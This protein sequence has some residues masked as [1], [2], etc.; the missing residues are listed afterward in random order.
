MR[1]HATLLV[2]LIKLLDWSLILSGGALSFY[3]LEASKNFPAYQG[4]MPTSYL[5]A[6]G[7]AFLFSAWWF[8]AFNVYKSWRGESLF[9]E[10]RT[11]LLSWGVSMMALLVFMVFT[12]TTTEFSRHWLGLWF[13]LVFVGLVLSRICLRLVLR[14]LRKKGLNQRHI[15]LVGSSVLTAQVAARVQ[16]S[17]WMGLEISGFFSDEKSAIDGLNKLG[18]LSKVVDYVEQHKVDQVWLTLS[19]KDMDKIETICRQLHS[20]SVEVLLIPDISSLRLLNHSISQIDG[21]PVINMSVSPMKG[22]N[23]IVKWLEDKLLSIFILL[24]ISPLMLII[25]FVVKLS[26]SGPVFYRQ[27]RI[28]W[29]GKRFQMLKFRSTCLPIVIKISSGAKQKTNAQHE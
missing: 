11:L 22:A 18:G 5:N 29:N 25:A 3:L 24:L 26:S 7:I 19:L 8:P 23:V 12:K 16:V 2:I 17:D 9:E 1:E 13:G 21:M 20:V 6:L 10:V 15:I 28:S 4:F 14:Y 27:E